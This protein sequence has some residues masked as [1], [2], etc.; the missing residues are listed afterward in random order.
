M[1]EIDLLT[2]FF[3]LINI[4]IIAGMGYLLCLLVKYLRKG[5]K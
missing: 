3:L 5:A 1:I 4:S 2:V